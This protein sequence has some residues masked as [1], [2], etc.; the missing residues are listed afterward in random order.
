MDVVLHWAQAVWNTWLPVHGLQT[1]IEYARERISKAVQ[2]WAVVTGPA[3]A[4]LCTLHR[5][6]WTVV[7]ATELCTDE[8]KSY[9][10]STSLPSL[11]TVPWRSLSGDGGGG[12]Y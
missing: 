9:D 10:L 12:I 2:P 6:G 4:L 5:V 8:G 11:S 7:S 3:A 1:S